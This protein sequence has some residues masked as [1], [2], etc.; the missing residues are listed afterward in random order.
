MHILLTNDDGVFAPGLAAVYR[1]LTK[2]GDVTVVA[3]AQPKSGAGHSISLEPLVCEKLD[4]TG[5]FEAYSVEG[6]PADCVKVVLNHLVET[7]FGP[8]DLVVSGMNHGANVGIHVFYSG[9]VAAAVEGA[10]YGV[11]SIALSAMYEENLDIEAAAEYGFRVIEQLLPLESG[12]VVNVNIPA[13]PDNFQ[14][15]DQGRHTFLGIAGAEI[16]GF[17]TDREAFIGSYR[18]YSNPVVVEE[19]QCKGTLASGDNGCGTLQVNLD[20]APGETKEFTVVM[21]I[22]SASDE[23]KAIAA[24]PAEGPAI[25]EDSALMVYMKSYFEQSLSRKLQVVT[26]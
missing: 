20:L 11:P 18:S 6:S 16:S 13:M 9:T 12:D 4:I 5:K 2:L 25:I 26:K 1:H 22:G 19:G 15:K 7:S 24:A 8:V 10:F 23:G 14:E 21:G 3:P 17:D